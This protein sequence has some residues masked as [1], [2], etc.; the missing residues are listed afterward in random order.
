MPHQKLLAYHTL[1]ALCTCHPGRTWW[2]NPHGHTTY[3][4]RL[5]VPV[6]TVSRTLP[7]DTFF[8]VTTQ[9][10]YITWDT[11]SG[12]TERTVRF[13]L[14]CV[15]NSLCRYLGCPNILRYKLRPKDQAHE[16]ASHMHSHI[17]PSCKMQWKDQAYPY[18]TQACTAL[19]S[20][21][22]RWM[23]R[24]L[25]HMSDASLHCSCILPFKI[26]SQSQAHMVCKAKCTTSPCES[27]AITC[28]SVT[29]SSS[30]ADLVSCNP[31]TPTVSAVHCPPR[32]HASL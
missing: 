24:S 12:Y 3:K 26:P 28:E 17:I 32:F 18:S 19:S 11:L 2:R 14:D 31:G 1:C 10:T 30:P 15:K 7:S 22:W 9:T 8:H 21:Q 27:E 5:C 13:G 23:K 25:Q 16:I 29:L 20:T 6:L 4:Q